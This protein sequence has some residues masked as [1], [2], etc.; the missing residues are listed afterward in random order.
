MPSVTQIMQRRVIAWLM[1]NELEGMWKKAVVTNLTLLN[2]NQGNEFAL[3]HD[4]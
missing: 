3:Q 1:N 2:W 4:K